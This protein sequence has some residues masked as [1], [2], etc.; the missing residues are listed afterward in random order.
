MMTRLEWSNELLTGLHEIDNQHRKLF[1]QITKFLDACEQGQGQEVLLETL[2][3]LEKYV[4]LHFVAE[5][6][7]QRIHNY[8]GLAGHQTLHAALL[9]ELFDYK[10]DL[11]RNGSTPDML[12]RAMQAWAE[13]FVHHISIDDKAI[14]DF[15]RKQRED[16]QTKA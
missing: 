13:W 15:L 7:L 3:F 10:A 14:A 11:L 12:S 9:A 5:E 2:A 8:P 1:S 4:R 6:Q 16:E